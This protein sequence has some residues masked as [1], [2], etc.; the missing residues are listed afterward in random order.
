MRRRTV[1]ERAV[2][3]KKAAQEQEQDKEIK[4][5]AGMTKEFKTLNAKAIFKLEHGKQMIYE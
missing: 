1:N 3:K 5:R 4:R 2:R